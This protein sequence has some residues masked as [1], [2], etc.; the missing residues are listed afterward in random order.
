MLRIKE[1]EERLKARTPG[2]WKTQF[3]GTGLPLVAAVQTKRMKY[4]RL[5][6]LGRVVRKED[7]ALIVAAPEDLEFLTRTVKE[8]WA[9]EDHAA[10]EE[11]FGKDWRKR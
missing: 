3:G 8:M 2:K 11:V 4:S 5:T 6:S 10:V 7:A 1:I 9:S